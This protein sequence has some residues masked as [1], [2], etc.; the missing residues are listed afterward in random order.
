MTAPTS[1]IW[2]RVAL[3]AVEEELVMWKN[4]GFSRIQG[5]RVRSMRR[6]ARPRR[7]R[8]SEGVRSR[9]TLQ[10]V[11]G[12]LPRGCTVEMLGPTLTS[13][14]HDPGI[15]LSSCFVHSTCR[16]GVMNFSCVLQ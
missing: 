13:G 5:A 4:I 15:I 7:S 3:T 10:V 1:A 11:K 12:F 14:I 8:Q 9:C 2:S 16:R 6:L